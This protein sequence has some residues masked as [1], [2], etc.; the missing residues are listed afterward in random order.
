[1][2]TLHAYCS[3]MPSGYF[4]APKEDS[5]MVTS[6]LTWGRVRRAIEQFA[7]GSPP[8]TLIVPA[9]F[10]ANIY[11]LWQHPAL[12]VKVIPKPNRIDLHPYDTCELL[13][14]KMTIVFHCLRIC[15][16]EPSIVPH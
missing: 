4:D 6:V 14:E 15:N 5:N 10:I 16:Y 1:M 2:K 9:E 13:F 7:D 12:L 11:E 3:T 8:Y